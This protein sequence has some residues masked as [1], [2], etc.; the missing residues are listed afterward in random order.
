MGENTARTVSGSS[1]AR[2]AVDVAKLADHLAV[3]IGTYLALAIAE[4]SS[5]VSGR[6]TL[7]TA[8]TDYQ[9]LGGKVISVIVDEVDNV[10]S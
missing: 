3:S 8:I 5:G 2:I 1:E 10:H 7:R 9:N 6:K 4:T